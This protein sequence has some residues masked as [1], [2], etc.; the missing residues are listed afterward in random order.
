M[1]IG[2]HLVGLPRESDIGESIVR[3]GGAAAVAGEVLHSA[4]DVFAMMSA[5]KPF[6]VASH[7][8]RVGRETA[9][10]FAYHGA[11]GVDID[12]D[13]GSYVHVHAR[14]GQIGRH[15]RGIVSGGVAVVHLAQILVAHSGVEAVFGFQSSHSATL[16][17]ESDEQVSVGIAL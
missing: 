11:V 3:V 1:A 8:S 9:A 7:H 2:V 4:S 15:H 14:P 10:Q 16:L 13:D 17:V 6:G 12:I 5:N